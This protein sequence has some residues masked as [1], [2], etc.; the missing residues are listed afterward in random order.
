MPRATSPP[1][2]PPDLVDGLLD[3]LHRVSA[4]A[5]LLEAVGVAAD[6]R[7]LRDGTLAGAG[8]IIGKEAARMLALV[9]SHEPK[10]PTP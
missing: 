1:S 4:V 2:L 8:D 9:R 3:G 10:S 7:R 5:D 6:P